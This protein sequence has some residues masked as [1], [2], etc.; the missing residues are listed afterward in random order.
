MSSIITNTSP[1]QNAPVKT[2]LH[3]LVKHWWLLSINGVFLIAAGF[4]IIKSPFQTYLALSKV[5]AL[6]MI[7][8]G[9][10][11][12]FFAWNNRHNK[13][14][15][16]RFPAGLIDLATG[17]FLFN[18]E[19]IAIFI[20]PLMI[21]IWTLLKAFIALG[22]TFHIR[23]Y[24]ISN[25]RRVMFLALVIVVIA[26]LLLLCPAIGIENIF[27]FSG[28]ALIIIGCFRIFLSLKLYKIKQIDKIFSQ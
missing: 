11:D 17:V 1:P 9:L 8:T 7:C 25:W 18:N 5:F 15:T 24:N 6:S 14:W 10:L 13:R 22:D 3:I 16:W 4:W 28:A 27:L 23:N 21:G 20:F 26:I 12:I 2:T 19:L